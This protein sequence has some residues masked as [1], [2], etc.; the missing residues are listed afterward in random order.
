[1]NARWSLP[2]V[3]EWAGRLSALALALFWGAFF[4]EH[5]SEWFMRG[6][7]RV[8]PP[9][10]WFAQ[11]L[12]LAMLCGLLLTLIKPL[13]GALAILLTS[14]AFF[15]WIRA[16]PSIAAVNLIP[17]ALVALALLLRKSPARAHP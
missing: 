4:I 14:L 12:H 8:P 13:P 15:G 7:G 2:S 17:V 5:L 10:V 6:D 1:M 11:I 9:F 16:F 3:L